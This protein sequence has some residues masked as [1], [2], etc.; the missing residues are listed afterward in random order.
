MKSP[1]QLTKSNVEGLRGEL[2]HMILFSLTWA[3]IGEYVLNFADYAAGAG[4][5]LIIV[6][7]LTFHL[8]GADL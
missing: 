3:L 2:F 8:L 5:I 4:L 6:V 1:K 7:G